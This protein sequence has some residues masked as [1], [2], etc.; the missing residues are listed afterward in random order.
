MFSWGKPIYYNGVG[1]QYDGDN[2]KL[3]VSMTQVY[4]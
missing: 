4:D 2:P 1:N 3:T